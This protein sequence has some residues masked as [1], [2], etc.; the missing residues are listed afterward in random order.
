[1]SE[2]TVPDALSAHEIIE[3]MALRHADAVR[4]ELRKDCYLNAF[5]AYPKYRSRSYF[6]IDLDNLGEG[7]HIERGVMVT[8]A[9]V[10]SLPPA[11]ANQKEA[12]SSSYILTP[13]RPPNVVR[14]ES[15]Q[16]IPAV[17]DTATGRKEMRSMRFTKRTE[18][19]PEHEK[20]E[21]EK[22]HDPKKPGQPGQQPGQPGQPQ[23]PGQQ[24]PKR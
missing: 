9:S 16:P 14:Q 15:G 17:V 7:V 11:T 12:W 22:E 3:D 23:H 13:E 4:A 10:E 8:E 1:M 24:E 19:E 21:H 18:H 5:L 2:V 20:K 6:E